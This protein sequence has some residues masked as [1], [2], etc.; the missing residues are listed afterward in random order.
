M[1]RDSKSLL[2]ISVLLLVT[3]LL[4]FFPEAGVEAA[5]QGVSLCL[6]LMI[7]S[8]FPF[9]VLSSLLISTGVAG[10][11]ARALGPI[12]R[13]LFGVSGTGAIPL[14]LG[15]VGGYPAGARILAQLVERG[16]CT[17]AEARRLSLFCNNCGPA[18]LI[19]VA[20]VG[21]FGSKQAGFLLLWANLISALLLGLALRLFK[22]RLPPISSPIGKQSLTALPEVLPDCVSSSFSA[23]LGVCAYVILFSVF[24]ALADC[25]GLLPLCVR[26]LSTIF[27]GQYAA[28]LCRSLLIGLGEISTGTAA[29]SD[30]VASPLALPLAAFLL[31]WGG[32]SVHCQSLAFWRMAQ[33]RPGSCLKAKLAQGL[34]SAGLTALLAPR[35]PR[36]LPAVAALPPAFPW[37]PLVRGEM[38]ALWLL[39]G[40]YFFL[41]GKKRW[42]NR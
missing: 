13:P 9:F 27:P 40:G 11:C 3:A 31:G 35:L 19:S 29:L 16:E 17:V 42:K 2:W 39:A 22:G 1:K 37:L 15:A 12:M 5:R 21:V 34:L 24:T 20:G 33:V 14:L 32:L 6:D 36:F 26:G 18:F 10:L 38:V 8:L 7:P 30:A 4:F 41:S 28:G 25:S 23:V